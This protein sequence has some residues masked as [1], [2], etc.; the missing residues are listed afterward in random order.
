MSI[1]SIIW[2]GD[3]EPTLK[4]NEIMNFFNKFNIKPL[5]FKLIKDKIKSK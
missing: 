4:E 3:I 5:S 1:N 2:M